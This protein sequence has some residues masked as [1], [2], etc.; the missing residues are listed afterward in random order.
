MA[1][2]RPKKRLGQNF[3]KSRAIIGRIVG[4]LESN[5]G[6]MVIEIGPGKGALTLPL[7]ESGA[8]I[9]PVEFD[10]DLI[11][12]LKSKLADYGN[13]HLVNADFLEFEPEQYGLGAFKLVGNLPYN[14][15]SP[16]I[17]WCLRHHAQ[18]Q[19]A[20]FMVQKEMAERLAGSPGS[21]AWAPISIFTQMYFKVERCFNV[22]PRY[23]SP[24]PKVTSSVI[25]LTPIRPPV[26]R[27]TPQLE[28]VV[29]TSFAHR[30]KKLTN[31]LSPDIV[32]EPDT[33]RAILDRLGLKETVR[34][35]E[36]TIDQF[37]TLTDELNARK[38]L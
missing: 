8:E 35:E 2:H 5:A 19:L 11:E 13:V 25:K 17:D 27:I 37:L 34:A 22:P 24:P 26:A 3:L 18:I 16:T 20:V 12:R 4:Q 6:E 9:W 36:L 31:N 30:R 14:I 21:K 23:F 33:L 10:R 15:T 7:A 38:L 1:G 28:K 29:R 32:P